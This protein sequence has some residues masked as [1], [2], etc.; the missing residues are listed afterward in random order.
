M[1][2]SPVT[3]AVTNRLMPSTGQKFTSVEDAITERSDSFMDV[4]KDRFTFQGALRS[5]DIAQLKEAQVQET[6]RQLAQVAR[7]WRSNYYSKKSWTSWNFKRY[8]S[9]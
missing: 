7:L 2:S 1:A 6:R 5:D 8:R 4:I 3:T 9:R